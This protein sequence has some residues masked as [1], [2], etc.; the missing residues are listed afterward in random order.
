VSKNLRHMTSIQ[1]AAQELHRRLLGAPWYIGV[2][3]MTHSAAKGPVSSKQDKQEIVVFVRD[4][5]GVGSLTTFNSWPVR[6]ELG[7]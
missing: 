5:A 7:G 2:Q 3:V 1:E 6:Y 4:L